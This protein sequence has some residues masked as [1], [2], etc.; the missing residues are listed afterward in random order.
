MSLPPIASAL[1]EPPVMATGWKTIETRP[2][3]S[4]HRRHPGSRVLD[5]G[6]PFE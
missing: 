2:P 5:Q 4:P 1:G 3:I 6:A